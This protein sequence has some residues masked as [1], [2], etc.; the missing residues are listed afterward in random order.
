MK[1]GGTRIDMES[2][3]SQAWG[4]YLATMSNYAVTMPLNDTLINRV[5]RTA[6]GR[7]TQNRNSIEYKQRI[8][9]TVSNIIKTTSRRSAS[10]TQI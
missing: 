2:P 3:V 7:G 4:K 1:Y 6:Q 8:N 5:I 9:N 10:H